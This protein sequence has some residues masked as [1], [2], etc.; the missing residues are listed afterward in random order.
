M[1]LNREIILMMAI[2]V[3]LSGM[4]GCDQIS[5]S[6]QESE[7]IQ[8]SGVVEAIS[9]EVSPEIAGRVAE[10]FA[11]EGAPVGSGEPL[12]RLEDNLLEGQRKQAEASLEVANANRATAQ[13]A[14]EAAHAAL[15]VAE[16][17]LE[18]VT[19][20]SEAELIPV[21]TNLENLYKSADVAS[22]EARGDVVTVT[23]A[24][25]DA[26]YAIDQFIIP[27]EQRGY[28]A[29]EAVGVMEERLQ[30]ARKEYEPFK[31]GTENITR[32]RQLKEDLDEAQSNYD[33][34]LSRLE[35]EAT[36]EGAQTKLD[37]AMNDLEVLQD[38][39]DPDAIA[40][41]EA[42][43]KALETAP[44]QAQALVDQAGIGIAQAESGLTGADRLVE[45]A[46]AA[47]DLITAQLEKLVISAPVTG[48]ILVRNVQPGEVIQP[49]LT[50]MTI[51][52]LDHLTVTVYVPED[53]YGQIELGDP[54]E[55]TT[56]SFPGEVFEAHVTRIA[57]QAE[58]TPRNVQT[59]EERSTT[60][61][62]IELVV[63]DQEAK[64]KPG[65]PV[66][67]MFR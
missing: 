39:P 29:A 51:G 57:D 6:D 32:K 62:A 33:S 27:D 1:K 47:L 28:T 2:F 22:S 40:A 24:V 64:L 31:N 48:V 55:V 21:Q 37:K 67:V 17:N 19:A 34:A 23:R 3:V 5:A 50:A 49:G 54:V 45:Q 42:Q 66:D 63:D 43:I 60:V 61:F 11:E 36:L 14:L 4:V 59:Q 20:S 38:G 26:Q 8:A 18:A 41:L 13:V 25:R 56:D 44:R 10:V 7:A 52:K 30:E 9:V 65:M 46:Q 12:F 58:Y 35:L 15:K 16:A 53:Q